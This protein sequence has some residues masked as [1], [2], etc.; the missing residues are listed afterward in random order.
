M[1]LSSAW[2][3]TRLTP[4]DEI[5]AFQSWV[6][7]PH[8]KEGKSRERAWIPLS[9]GSSPARPLTSSRFLSCEKNKPFSLGKGDEG[10]GVGKEKTIWINCVPVYSQMYQPKWHRQAGSDHIK[11]IGQF[12][13]AKKTKTSVIY[14]NK[15][16]VVWVLC[17]AATHVFLFQSLTVLCGIV[18]GQSPGGFIWPSGIYQ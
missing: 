17:W 1:W 14:M 10:S 16:F 18:A 7:K 2:W 9:S 4:R 3:D 11:S 6:N 8:R 12:V 13:S 5:S 15:T